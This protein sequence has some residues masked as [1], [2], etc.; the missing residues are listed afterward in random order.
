[1]SHPEP[2]AI[3]GI[4]C[5]YPGGV[6]DPA[7]FWRL[8]MDGVDAI[9][10][11]PADRWSIEKFYDPRP[12]TPGKSVSKWGGFIEHIDEFDAGFFRISA[13][14]APCVDP[15]QRLLLQTAW[16]AFEDAGETAE[17]LQGTKA[18]VF[19]GISA[20]DYCTMQAS[21]ARPGGVDV[22]TATGGLV[23]IAANRLSFCFDLRGPSIAVDTACSSSLVA[24]HLAC[25]SLRRGEIPLALVAG[26]N[27]LLLPTPFINFSTANMLSPDGRCKAFDASA[28]G[29][30]RAEGAGAIV[31][32]PL[33]TARADG[34]LIYAVIRGTACNQ[35]GRN[36]GMTI[37][38]RAA[39]AELVREA[40]RQA[41]ATPSAIQYVE[42]HGTGTAV[43]DP[44]EAG[45]LG[46]A[47]SD[48]RESG[49][50]CLIGSVKTN[51]G[52]LEAGAG[53][54]GVIKTALSLHHG[55]IPP[56]LHCSVPNPEIDFAGLG[57]AV[58]QRATPYPRGGAAPLAGVNS[59]GFGGA[60]AHAI[61]GPSP[62]ECP[63]A[64]PS[65]KRDVELLVLSARSEESLRAMAGRYADWLRAPG[66]PTLAGICRTAATSRTH[67]PFRA[68]VLGESAPEIAGRLENFAAAGSAEACWEGEAPVEAVAPVFVFCGQGSQRP[69]MGLELYASEPVFR[70][71]IDE[72]A[73]VYR[74]LA[75]WDLVTELRREEAA[76]KLN[77]TEFAQPSIFAVQMGVVE[78]LASWGIRPA[79]L[80]GHSVGEVAAACTSGA[81][82]LKDAA[83]VVLERARSMAA[84]KREGR[85]LSVGLP[86]G[87]ILE[88]L[89]DIDHQVCLGAVNSPK[90]VVL[91]G[92]REALERLAARFEAE[93][94]TARWLPVEY[95]FHSH[96]VDGSRNR[97]L[98][99]LGNIH[100]KPPH[101]HLVSTVHGGS[102]TEAD[103]DAGYWW[104][105][106]RH[107]VFFA[108]AIRQLARAGHRLFL[109]VGP[110]AVLAR[111]IMETLSAEKI[112]GGRVLATLR[113]DGRDR[114]ALL[115]AAGRLYLQ[116]SA[117]DW[118]PVFAH[119]QRT[120]LPSYAWHTSRHW[121]ED[122]SWRQARLESPGH[123]LLGERQQGQDPVWQRELA[124]GMADYLADHR[125]RGQ[126]VLPA[127]AYLEMALAAARELRG[128][129]AEVRIGDVD[130]RKPLVLSSSGESTWLRT[131]V[132]GTDWEILSSNDGQRWTVYAAGKFEI[133]EQTKPTSL[134]LDELRERMTAGMSPEAFYAQMAATGL[135]FGP[136]FRGIKEVW[137]R[138]GLAVAAIAPEV[139]AN[140]RYGVHP[141]MLDSCLQVLSQA[142]P[143]GS[144]TLFLP[145]NVRSATFRGSPGETAWCRA[146]LV[147]LG[148][149]LLEGNVDIANA[150]GE[151]LVS[152]RGLVCRAVGRGTARAGDVARYVWEWESAAE[153]AGAPTNLPSPAAI[154]ERLASPAKEPAQNDDSAAKEL[155]RLA[156]SLSSASPGEVARDFLS[157]HPRHWPQVALLARA[158]EAKSAVAEN[159]EWTPARECLAL[160]TTG[161]NEGTLPAALTAALLQWPA[162]RTLRALILGADRADAA[163]R[164]LTADSDRKVEIVV[165]DRREA[166]AAS[167]AGRH[168][169]ASHVAWEADTNLP[170]GLQAGTFDLVVATAGHQLGSAAVAQT[171]EL[172]RPSGLIFVEE[173]SQ[174]QKFERLVFASVEKPEF[175]PTE[176]LQAA[177]WEQV[178]P[179]G[180]PGRFSLLAAKRPAVEIA[181]TA[182][183]APVT[184]ASWLLLMDRTGCGE[185]LAEEL[186]KAGHHV[187]K[188]RW[189]EAFE[190]RPGDEFILRP[191]SVE[192]FSRLLQEARSVTQ[193]E[194]AGVI[195]LANLDDVH[196]S[197]WDRAMTVGTLS[198]APVVRALSEQ[199]LSPRLFVVTCGA[200]AVHDGEN[201][202]PKQGAAWGFTR[203]LMNEYPRLRPRLIDLDGTHDA[204]AQAFCL[205]GEL[206]REDAEDEIAWRGGTRFVH[207][208]SSLRE[209]REPSKHG[210]FV[211]RLSD[212]GDE[213]VL[214]RQP[215][216]TKP[217]G[218]GE[219]EISVAATGLNFR[220]VMKS[221]GIYPANRDE[222]FILGDECSGYV[223][224]VGP[225]VEDWRP[226]DE[227]MTIAPG[228]FSSRV[229]A[230]SRAIARKPSRLDFASAATVPV[231]FLTAWYGLRTLARL[232]PGETVL[233]HA[234]AGGVGLAA[235]QVARHSGAD[236]IATAGSPEKRAFLRALGIRHVLDSRGTSFGEEALQLTGGRGVD[237][238]LNSLAG[239]AIPRGLAC[240][241]P[242]GRFIEIGKRDI[243]ANSALGLRAFR[244]SISFLA[245][246]L[247]EVL[248]DQT[249]LCRSLLEEI[250]G[251]MENGALAPVPHRVLPMEELPSAFREMAQGRHIGKL[252]MVN[253][254]GPFPAPDKE[255]PPAR[256]FRP[257]AT[258]LVTGGTRGFGLAVAKWMAGQGAHHLLL[259]ARSGAA[260]ADSLEAIEELKALG[261]EPR[262]ARMDVSRADEVNGM[263]RDIPANAP[264]AGIFHAAAVIEDATVQ[265][266][267]AETFH[268][269]LAGKA[270]GAL[271]LHEASAGLPL[272]HFVL[273][274]SVALTVGNPGQAAYCAAN[275]FLAALTAARHAQGLPALCLDW[276]A[277]ASVGHAARKEGL[278]EVLLRAGFEG[279]T[280]DEAT[281]ALGKLLPGHGESITL[282]KIDWPRAAE[283]MPAVQKSPRFSRLVSA[284]GPSGQTSDD[285]LATLRR[286]SP[287]ERRD[288]VRSEVAAL[289]ARVVRTTADKL[290]PDKQL[291][292]IGF[293]SLMAIELINLVERRFE[294]T[295]PASAISSSVT[296]TQIAEIVAALVVEE[297]EPG[298]TDVQP[299]QTAAST[300]PQPR[301]A[302][303]TSNPPAGWLEDGAIGS[304]SSAAPPSLRYRAE[305]GGL[306]LLL[307]LFRG[308]TRTEA[309]RT[310]QH[311]LPVLRP[312]LSNDARWARKNLTAVFGPGLDESQRGRLADLAMENHLLSYVEGVCGGGVE[313]HF[314][315]YEPLLKA[316]AARH[317]IILCG[318]HL[319]TWEPL[320]RWG[321]RFGVPLAGV[322]RRA[323]NPLADRIFQ[324]IRSTYGIRWVRSSETPGMISALADGAVLGMMTDLNTFSGGVFADFLGL[325]ASCPAG[326]AALA[327]HTGAR[328][329]PAVAIR[330]SETQTRVIFGD[331]IEPEGEL[332]GDQIRGLTRR[333]NAAFEPWILN[334]AEQY[335]WLHPR[336]RARP[337]GPAWT[338]QTP[339]AEIAAARVENYPTVPPRV[340][341]LLAAGGDNA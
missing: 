123:P 111:P 241:A 48:G 256:L 145:V 207:R 5:R 295:L 128:G 185:N 284:L 267:E 337:E 172:L 167:I 213:R 76:T 275:G 287:E 198:L 329:V 233:I 298:P 281:R 187:V 266:L 319:G 330:E 94:I 22:W 211:W 161:E 77:I 276:G 278:A 17:S 252:V 261:A 258:Y 255:A 16:E 160:S 265:T 296:T 71:V 178:T 217:P 139:D 318:V 66:A 69:G 310:L 223:V 110:Q 21:P 269:V 189:G 75:G 156:E 30:V 53:V 122:P 306:H 141:A 42:T 205:L 192:D 257:D 19:V 35:D 247:A 274:S 341:G 320:L 63:T 149:R 181:P 120:R 40:C 214:V 324:Q 340:L 289:V 13:R 45:A 303:N 105:N 79:A 101:T 73:A 91:S 3:T 51:I 7:S 285:F 300:R 169:A 20:N 317:G 83:R 293:D 333:L 264:L 72:C 95:S 297:K 335:N 204:A 175:A 177:G 127:A 61:L 235:L 150:N 162:G 109:E 27:A 216:P 104:A 197:E 49:S 116:G 227:V 97:L 228:C 37:P 31:L 46:D 244:H 113:R 280:P 240:L 112:C 326:P 43:G 312:F 279:L 222:D 268:H 106:V 58:V 124:P 18:G 242:H 98:A 186:T 158:V 286:A 249:D 334:Y 272:D 130:F 138:E 196:A 229:I 322:Y 102:A 29:Y 220:D 327:Q 1:M 82:D 183:T 225:G 24:L 59:F 171:I 148:Q 96:H 88:F 314:E 202:E 134:D 125:V 234:A 299:D 129:A 201:V 118:R 246:D 200:L 85:M 146:S 290:S 182:L 210:R 115:E 4:G 277:I 39:Q 62:E 179:L 153:P 273:F 9:T 6:T 78:L 14:E 157:A 26:V 99:A 142:L 136:S 137:R 315:N 206:S 28:N 262:V 93:K 87:E 81:L 245:F 163:A 218:E 316:H 339:D 176:A 231:A 332:A 188:A 301:L 203:V 154:N 74:S 180:T 44:V 55:M 190:H 33:A 305:A 151:I 135:E 11:I 259:A 41:G 89:Q 254:A 126:A 239:E 313:E 155:N 288:L 236:I 307:R 165:T 114:A 147:N 215:Q 32:K 248:R 325:P 323:Q 152:V 173:Q 103:F 57:L 212:P 121:R 64:T 56:S 238:V 47:L 131:A 226:G 282:A 2:I 174:F 170:V 70:Q 65:A 237:V 308:K 263:L 260:H 107:P 8:L 54:A 34:D 50:A 302:A 184:P 243:Y 25:E 328:L 166:A 336:W 294:L 132:R 36:K 331:P 159:S 144:D 108:G 23:S 250:G 92:D 292:E 195:H 164:V 230:P 270:H 232:Q 60:N 208:L 304:S 86:P 338:L 143:P 191:D 80:T 15:Q 38:S 140:T 193:P 84:P 321:P 251:L 117:V 133:A 221:L 52:H 219:V 67:Q 283:I 90:T 209:V 224:A 10:E 12:G 253:E 311:L 291:Q 309:H 199:Q 68:V 119:G 168:E 100:A 194:W 271:N